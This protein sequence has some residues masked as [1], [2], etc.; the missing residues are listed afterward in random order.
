[1]PR[2]QTVTSLPVYRGSCSSWTR[3]E[4]LG[5]CSPAANPQCILEPFWNYKLQSWSNK[6]LWESLYIWLLLADPRS[7]PRDI[8]EDGWRLLFWILPH[9]DSAA[10]PVILTRGPLVCAAAPRFPTLSVHS[11]SL[12]SSNPYSLFQH[13]PPCLS[14]H[15][16]PTEWLLL[17]LEV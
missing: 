2:T 4:D 17:H 6:G 1:M 3:A 16:Q 13:H 7:W 15:Q 14:S 10:Q 8:E 9:R 12:V 11:C 5:T